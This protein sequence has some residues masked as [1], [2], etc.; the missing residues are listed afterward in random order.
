MWCTGCS[1]RWWSH[2]PWWCS[3]TMEMWHWGTSLVD[4]VEM[5][6]GLDCGWSQLS[7]P[8]LKIL[9]FGISV[10]TGCFTEPAA[11]QNYLYL[12]SLW[13]SQVCSLAAFYSG[14]ILENNSKEIFL[15]PVDISAA[16]R[17]LDGSIGSAGNKPELQN[18][19][20]SHTPKH[21]SV[22]LQ[23]RELS[24]WPSAIGSPI[25]ASLRASG[26]VSVL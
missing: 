24:E 14:T 12:T 25:A 19:E 20:L 4:M 16:F 23:V 7:S 22:C 15:E 5:G 3:R 18:W 13:Q 1:G 17:S 10:W 8:T 9:W 11:L 6:W 21:A 2:H 26:V